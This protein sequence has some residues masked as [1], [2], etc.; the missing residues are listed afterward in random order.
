ME[1]NKTNGYKS[2]NSSKTINNNKDSYIERIKKTIYKL[3]NSIN[4]R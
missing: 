4:Y 2:I 1:F 3:I